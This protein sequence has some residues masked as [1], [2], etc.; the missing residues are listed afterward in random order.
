MAITTKEFINKQKQKAALDF[1]EDSNTHVYLI[2]SET[3]D[4]PSN[5][6]DITKSNIPETRQAFKVAPYYAINHSQRED[7]PENDFPMIEIDG[8]VFFYM[9][10][11]PANLS[12]FF[13]NENDENRYWKAIVVN[14]LLNFETPFNYNTIMLVSTTVENNFN[15]ATVITTETLGSTIN[16]EAGNKTFRMIFEF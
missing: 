11:Q 15:N 2:L 1:K 12:T 8:L 3:E 10:T 13:K 16:Q 7:W 6:E 4:L 14:E 9:R 5:L